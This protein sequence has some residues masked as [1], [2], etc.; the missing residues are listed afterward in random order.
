MLNDAD[1]AL[2]TENDMLYVVRNYNPE[3]ATA[4]KLNSAVQVARIEM[5]KL[6]TSNATWE[7]VEERVNMLDLETDE[8]GGW[9]RVY[10]SCIAAN[11]FGQLETVETIKL[12]LTVTSYDIVTKDYMFYQTILVYDVANID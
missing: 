3:S 7:I 1:Y 11:G 8:T 9:E 6:Y 4:P 10:S 12:G 5:S 2:D